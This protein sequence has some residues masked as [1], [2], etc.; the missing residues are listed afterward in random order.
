MSGQK[1]TVMSPFNMSMLNWLLLITAP[2]EQNCF[3]KKPDEF[4]TSKTRGTKSFIDSF[5][6]NIARTRTISTKSLDKFHSGMF[7]ETTRPATVG[8]DVV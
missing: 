3:S 8:R 5:R 4:L 1:I 6:Q 2:D 7:P